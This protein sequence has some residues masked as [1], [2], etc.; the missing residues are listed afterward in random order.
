MK[1]NRRSFLKAALGCGLA[2]Y[3]PGVLPKILPKPTVEYTTWYKPGIWALPKDLASGIKGMVVIHADKNFVF[4][5]MDH[6]AWAI[7]DANNP[8]SPLAREV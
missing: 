6:D 1:R 5:K 8:G 3:V 2:V 4:M 7:R